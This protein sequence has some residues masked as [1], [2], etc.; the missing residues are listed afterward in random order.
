MIQTKTNSRNFKEILGGFVQ[1]VRPL[2][3]I[4]SMIGVF[5]GYSLVYGGFHFDISLLYAL[6]A[7]FCI[8]GGGQAINDYFD[9]EIDR[10]QKTNRPL[11]KGVVSR[12]TGIIFS[13][14]LFALGMVLA[15]YLS[16]LA[17]WIAVFFSILLI[18]YSALMQKIK[19]VG[20]VIVS[21]GVAFT[22]VFGASVVA[23]TPLVLMIAIPAFFANWAR[24][25][26]KDIED[27][28]EDKGHKITLPQLLKKNQVQ[29]FTFALFGAAIVTG[30][31]PT[32]FG[33]GD[34]KYPVLVTFSNIVFILAAHQLMKNNARKSQSN[35]KKGMMVG[36]LAQ[37]SLMI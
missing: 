7:V 29:W 6:L 11:V 28:A 1:L 10:K 14:A 8:S 3:A 37:L 30:Y 9:Y 34:W 36:L 26:V 12:K 19:F 23:I 15:S 25:I 2:N 20:N 27:A 21:L 32:I 35:I 4:M 18:L 24:E 16:E 33:F 5:I 22:F 31:L 17:F 13:F